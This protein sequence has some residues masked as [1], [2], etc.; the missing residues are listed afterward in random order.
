MGHYYDLMITGLKKIIELL[1][2]LLI[3][4]IVVGLVFGGDPLG[5][6]NNV[7]NVTASMGDKGLGAVLAVVLIVL[8]YRRK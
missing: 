1:V 3:V 6:M 7:K 4:G 2:L 5:V 8:M